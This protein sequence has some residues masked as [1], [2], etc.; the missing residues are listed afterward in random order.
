MA[1]HPPPTH[2]EW[3]PSLLKAFEGIERFEGMA[4]AAERLARLERWWSSPRTGHASRPL[5]TLE[6]AALMQRD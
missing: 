6:R 4:V 2:S 5:H 1:C 3:A